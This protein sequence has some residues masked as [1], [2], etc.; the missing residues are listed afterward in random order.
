MGILRCC[1]LRCHHDPQRGDAWLEHASAA[2]GQ[3]FVAT[4]Q[5]RHA[6]AATRRHWQR[7]SGPT[8]W[9]PLNAAVDRWRPATGGRHPCSQPSSTARSL[10]RTATTRHSR[11]ASRRR[12]DE[13]DRATE[14]RQELAGQRYGSRRGNRQALARSVPDRSGRRS[15]HRQWTHPTT[16]AHRIP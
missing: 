14:G 4:G 9:D 8:R 7:Y 11:S 13:R 10:S 2:V 3:G 5:D 12:N 16:S 1:R 6:T 15:D